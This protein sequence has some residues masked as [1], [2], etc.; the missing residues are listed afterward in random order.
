[1]TVSKKT[2]HRANKNVEVVIIKQDLHIPDS[3]AIQMAKT[4][5]Q[6]ELDNE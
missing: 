4:M 1:M 5:L 3:V 6:E 2:I